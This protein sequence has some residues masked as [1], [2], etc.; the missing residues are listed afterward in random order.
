MRLEAKVTKVR[1]TSAVSLA[2]FLI[3]FLQNVIFIYLNNDIVIISKN[4]M[5][6]LDKLLM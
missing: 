3:D 2:F 6:S 4:S 5:I 1:E